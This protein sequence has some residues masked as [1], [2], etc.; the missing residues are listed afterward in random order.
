MHYIMN[1]QHFGGSLQ[2][3]FLELQLNQIY[4]NLDMLSLILAQVSKVLIL[5]AETY[6]SH[7]I[8]HF[9]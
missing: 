1:E 4:K 7:S 6:S 2:R 3:S 9:S 5:H 8:R